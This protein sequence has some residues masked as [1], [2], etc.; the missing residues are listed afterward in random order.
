MP[1]QFSLFVVS[2]CNYIF[3]VAFGLALAKST[4]SS[5][6]LYEMWIMPLPGNGFLFRKALERVRFMQRFPWACT[7]GLKPWL[8]LQD[9]NEGVLLW[10]YETY[11]HNLS[12]VLVI[13]QRGPVVQHLHKL[14][15][16]CKILQDLVDVSMRFFFEQHSYKA[17]TKQIWTFSWPFISE[18]NNLFLMKS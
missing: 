17:A 2:A 14:Q 3:M 13:L 5:Q 16:S 4:D 15:Y 8:L 9:H 7:R 10:I 6:K 11:E 18:P 12:G 1:I